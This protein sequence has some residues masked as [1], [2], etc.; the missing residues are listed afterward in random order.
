MISSVGGDD[1]TFVRSVVDIH[2]FDS[3]NED[4]VPGVLLIVLVLLGRRE[5]EH[6]LPIL[7]NTTYQMDVSVRTYCHVIDP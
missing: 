7:M 2:R 4:Q 6:S 3:D 5:E 1:D